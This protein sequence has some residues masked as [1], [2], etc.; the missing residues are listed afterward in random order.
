M[1]KFLRTKKIAS[2]L[3]D[4]I[5]QAEEYLIIVSPYLQLS[6]TFYDRL[7]QADQRSVEIIII[8]GKDDLKK[9]EWDKLKEL[10]S[11]TVYFMPNLHAKCYYNEFEMIISS[12][13]F[14]FIYGCWFRR[15]CKMVDE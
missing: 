4:I 3:E 7:Y 12:M 5:I 10:K 8:Y 13:N 14:Y 9:K 6:E 11:T 15:F 1:A 2:C